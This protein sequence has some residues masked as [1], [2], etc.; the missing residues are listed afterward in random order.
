SSVKLKGVG[1]DAPKLTNC[2]SPATLFESGSAPSGA[3]VGPNVAMAAD[4]G[5]SGNSQIQFSRSNDGGATFS[6]PVIISDPNVSHQDFDPSVAFDGGG[7]VF[8]AFTG[9]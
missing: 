8:V 9:N 5:E 7:G 3:V 2:G 1:V 6:T 4:T